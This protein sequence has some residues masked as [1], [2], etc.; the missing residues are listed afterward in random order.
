MQLE[1]PEVLTPPKVVEPIEQQQAGEMVKLDT[2]V[3]PD[4]DHKVDEFI[5]TIISNDVMSEAFQQKLRAVHN[6]GNAEIRAAA[7]VSN[8]LLD[9]PVRAMNEGVFDDGAPISKSLVELRNT[10]E[11]LDPTR[12][13]DL[14]SPR[15]ILG[16]IPL[17]NK[18][19]DYFMRYKSSQS[20]INAIIESLYRGQDELRKDNAA[21]EQEK[22]N[23]WGIM[24]TLKQYIYVGK[25]IDQRISEKI[26][27]IARTDPEKARV[28]QEELLFYVRQKVTDLQTQMAV[29]IQGYLALDMVRKN[30]LELVKGVDR[31]TTT[32]VSA[33]RTAV[34]VAQAL[35]NEKLVLDQITALNTTTG[36]LIES[37]SSMLK[38]QSAKIYEQASSS[39]IEL[40]KLQK[41]FDNVFD[42]MDMISDYK[43]KA[44]DNMQKT[45]D[46]LS[47]EI[48]RAEGY[49]DRVRQEDVDETIRD[50]RLGEPTVSRVEI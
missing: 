36:N 41:A 6:M 22:V 34:I 12:Q 11:A 4:L 10:I 40:E 48:R 32:T 46:T 1:P 5:T 43:I 17:G 26:A 3:I 30:N 33:L 24:Q 35:I 20:H 47:S 14:F 23:I 7:S 37:T 50:L 9:K 15:K 39:T 49:L 25:K 27:D 29:S 21:V 18:V 44:L 31:A 8:R 2:K 45:V 42:T 38:T 13:G 19:R 16:I 28:V